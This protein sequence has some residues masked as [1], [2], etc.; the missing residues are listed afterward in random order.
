MDLQPG[1]Y[2]LRAGLLPDDGWVS[3]GLLAFEIVAGETFDA[4][5]FNLRPAVRPLSPAQRD[6]VAGVAPGWSVGVVLQ[7]EGVDQGV[8]PHAAPAGK[9][10]ELDPARRGSPTR[11]REQL[12]VRQLFC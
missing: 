8:D 12:S 4:G 11:R 2:A 6:T 3:T 1:F 7:D 5:A 9:M 10:D